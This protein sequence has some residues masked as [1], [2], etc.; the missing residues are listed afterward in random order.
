M[1]TYLIRIFDLL[2]KILTLFTKITSKNWFWSN[3][4]LGWKSANSLISVL[5]TPGVV[6]SRNIGP[7]TWHSFSLLIWIS[8]TVA[9]QCRWYWKL[10]VESSGNCFL[11][12]LLSKTIYNMLEIYE[13]L[14]GEVSYAIH[15]LDF[16]QMLLL[17]TSWAITPKL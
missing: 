7:K 6:L 5:N 9:S 12:G 2:L 13:K 14:H 11:N 10:F 16:C 1:K 8:T 4:S 17:F 3:V 15:S